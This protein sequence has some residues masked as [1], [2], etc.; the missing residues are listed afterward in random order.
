MNRYPAIFP[1]IVIFRRKHEVFLCNI[2][3]AQCDR[4]ADE[5]YI[6]KQEICN[7]WNVL[8]RIERER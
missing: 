3:E 1:K 6:K 5:K 4:Q 7:H 8:I 2:I